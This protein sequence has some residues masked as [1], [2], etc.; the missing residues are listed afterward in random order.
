MHLLQYWSP[1]CDPY[2]FHELQ[3]LE[4]NVALQLLFG[5]LRGYLSLVALITTVCPSYSSQK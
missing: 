5:K 1:G 3:L 4:G 2:S